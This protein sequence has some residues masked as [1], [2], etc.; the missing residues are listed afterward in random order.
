MVMKRIWLLG[1]VALF[2]MGC[3]T[4]RPQLSRE[5]WLAVTSRTYDGVTKEQVLEAAE[6]LFRLADGDDFVISHTEEGL[7]ATRNWLVY[8]IL[9][10]A[11][12]TDYWQLKAVPTPTGVNV[13][14][15][16]TTQ[17][18]SV[19]PIAVT[20]GGWTATT[21]PMAGTPVI[22]TAIYDVFWSRM[23]WCIREPSIRIW[24]YHS[25]KPSKRLC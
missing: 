3:A 22:G 10:G 17:A 4:T 6:R 2:A 1:L 11:M 15:Y 14:V 16:A 25:A 7:Y 12:G 8:L 21:T 24:T 23:D 13:T 20:T 9:A 5:E 19:V 18:G